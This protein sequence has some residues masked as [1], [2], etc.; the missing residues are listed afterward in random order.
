MGNGL[1]GLRVSMRELKDASSDMM[2]S[3]PFDA[4]ADRP[5]AIGGDLSFERLLSAY[6]H[7][8]F[9]WFDEPPILW[10][11]P[12]PRMVLAPADIRINR[13]LDKILRKTTFRVTFDTAF[14]AVIRAC[15]APRRTQA[16]TWITS[17]MVVAYE[18]L[19]AQGYAHSAECWLDG[20]LV[21][22]LYGVALGG[23]FFG[24]SMFSGVSNASKVAFV[25]LTRTLEK[26]GFVLIDCQ[27]PS[28]HLASLGATHMPRRDFLR[29]LQ[30][31]VHLP[32][33][34]DEWDTASRIRS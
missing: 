32:I 33:A 20:Q 8:I 34:V 5:L 22:G 29:I 3:F 31:A 2:W 19:F 10:W 16:G 27:V 15:S 6:A 9:P 1:R 26:R 21:G 4:P 7:G 30:D 12:D 14:G 18:A 13:S 24:E 23:V 17:E 25:A 11:S 28:T